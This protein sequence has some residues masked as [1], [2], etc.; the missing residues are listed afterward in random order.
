[1][2]E[3][4]FGLLVVFIIVAAVLAYFEVIDLF[5]LLAGIIKLIAALLFA[6]GAFFV[7]LVKRGSKPKSL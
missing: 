6:V 5:D 4:L 1:M 2:L 7:W 3:S